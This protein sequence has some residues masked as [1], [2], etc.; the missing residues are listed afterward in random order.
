ML[1]SVKITKNQSN[2][3]VSVP[4]S[5]GICAIIAPCQSGNTNQPLSVTNQ[6]DALSAYGYGTLTDYGAYMINTTGNPV[7]L[8][9]GAAS[10]AATY[11]TIVYTGTGTSVVTAGGTSPLDGYSV[12]VTIVAGGTRG[13]AGVTY[14][15][16]LDGGNNVSAVQ[17]LGTAV[18]IVIPNSGVSLA[19]GAGTFV[20]GDVITVTTTGP[21]M[22]TGDITTSLEALR[23]SALNW[24]C[25]LIGG[26]DAVDA[27]VQ[28]LD[29]WLA[30]R[31]AEGKYRFFVVNARAKTVGE[32]EAAYATAM[33]T[34][35]SATASIRG[36]V[37]A[38]GGN[39]VTAFPLQTLVKK[40]HTALAV[41]ARL[42]NVSYGRDAAYVADGP[43]NGFGL[44]DA[45]G[46]PVSHDESFYPG[47]DDQ[48]LVTLRTF[49]RRQGTFITN[50]NV[51][52]S[53]G[54]DFVYA[55][56]IRV[57]N[58]ACELAFDVLTSQLS[59]GIHKSPKTG[60]TGQVYIDEGDAQAIDALVNQ[61]LNQLRS[62]VTDLTFVLSRSD[63]IGQNGP[64][65]LN[66]QVSV[67]ALAYAKQFNVNAAFS[68]SISV[69][70]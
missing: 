7:I 52:S 28:L 9:R 40:K 43:V 61:S 65:T 64:I 11:G 67:E 59:K 57:M 56:H 39:V 25:V 3:G 45:Q 2:T 51:I 6:N 36:C 10:T 55:Q 32:S 50:P 24:E 31:E 69:Q 46:N 4:S 13:A 33:Q 68:R 49:P 29:G 38:D 12:I 66:G 23:T 30:A 5:Q 26:H 8:V 63:D 54:S 1:P 60:P 20:A 41:A 48:R 44:A 18:S 22:T 27:T 47:L 37:G 15:Y 21:K 58:R 35:W 17:A 34:A 42:M 70:Q 53:S 14:T 62:E 19:L 16:S